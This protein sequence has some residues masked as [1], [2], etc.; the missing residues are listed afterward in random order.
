MK[1]REKPR[2]QVEKKK[3]VK[4]VTEVQVRTVPVQKPIGKKRKSNSK[5]NFDI[6]WKNENRNIIPNIMN[7]MLSF[8]E[9]KHK[10]EWL[11][12]RLFEKYSHSENWTIA[13]YYCYMKRMKSSMGHYI[14][15]NE[16]QAITR[17]QEPECEIYSSE[18]QMFYLKICR[19]AI[20]YFFKT[21]SILISLTSNRMSEQ[22]RK[23]H[24]VARRALLQRMQQLLQ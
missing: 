6:E 17:I 13:K 10:S 16:L 2:R 9:K 19:I 15:E 3:K 5:L 11:I 14:N 1:K 8:V 22:K 24:L 12:V 7:Q 4:E 18:E 23:A 20:D 21:Q